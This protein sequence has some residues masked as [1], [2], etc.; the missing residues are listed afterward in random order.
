M[1]SASR[2]AMPSNISCTGARTACSSGVAAC[3]EE[4]RKPVAVATAKK[5]NQRNERKIFMGFDYKLKE[6][7]YEVAHARA[8][9]VVRCHRY[10]WRQDMKASLFYRIA[11]VLLLLFAVGHTLGFR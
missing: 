8:G 1:A 9:T 6:N 11:A 10:L 2:F 7:S 5:K 4:I 3:N